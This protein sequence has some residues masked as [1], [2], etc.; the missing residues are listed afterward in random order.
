MEIYAVS[1]QGVELQLEG[2]VSLSS[3]EFASRAAWQV[4][5]T[6]ARFEPDEVLL[7]SGLSLSAYR[8]ARWQQARATVQLILAGEGAGLRLGPRGLGPSDWAWQLWLPLGSTK[9]V[10]NRPPGPA[11]QQADTLALPFPLASWVPYRVIV[12]TQDSTATAWLEHPIYWQVALPD[13]IEAASLAARDGDVAMVAGDQAMTLLADGSIKGPVPLPGVSSELRWWPRGATADAL[14]GMGVCLPD[15]HQVVY[16]LAQQ[17][18]WL[19]AGIARTY[20]GARLDGAD[21]SFILPLS[22]AIGPDGRIYV[23]DAATGQI[24]TFRASGKYVTRWGRPGTGPG[25]F[26]FGQGLTAA[27]YAGSIAVDD[28]GFIYVADPGNQRIQKFAP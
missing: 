5:P 11:G 9:A 15:Q 19:L 4:A 17:P 26:N 16:A 1:I 28:Q 18:L 14:R 24:Q 6:R 23:L 27:E 13:G 10:L 21:G 2:A 22:L 7:G 12:E 20:L 8:D 3:P 25:E